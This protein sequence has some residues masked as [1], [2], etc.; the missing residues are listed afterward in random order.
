MDWDRHKMWRLR[1]I[2]VSFL[3]FSV[4]HCN[5]YRYRAYFKKSDFFQYFNSIIFGLILI[6]LEMKFLHFAQNIRIFEMYC[7]NTLLYKL[8]SSWIRKYFQL[9]WFFFRNNNHFKHLKGTRKSI[10][11][12]AIFG[13][14]LYNNKMKLMFSDDCQ[15]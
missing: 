6:K 5:T 12:F 8:V 4:I 7:K 2:S 9:N 10:I 11:I 1:F 14:R 3:Y 15:L 13:K